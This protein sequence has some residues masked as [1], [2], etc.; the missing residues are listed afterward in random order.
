MIPRQDTS[1]SLLTLTIFKSLLLAIIYRQAG[2][3]AV[4][5]YVPRTQAEAVAAARVVVRLLQ[6]VE[7]LVCSAGVAHSGVVL[8]DDVH[9]L[10]VDVL[11]L[12]A[13]Y[14]LVFVGR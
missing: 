7:I 2:Q 4:G 12:L 9:I 8:S 11:L 13:V 5:V 1:K 14:K 3:F 6:D 10:I